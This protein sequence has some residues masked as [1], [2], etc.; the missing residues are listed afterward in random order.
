MLRREALS[1]VYEMSSK[2]RK[3]NCSKRAITLQILQAKKHLKCIGSIYRQHPRSRIWNVYWGYNVVTR[4][5]N[6]SH[7]PGDDR[8]SYWKLLRE[9]LINFEFLRSDVTSSQRT[10]NTFIE[11]SRICCHFQF[12]HIDH[13]A[14]ALNTINLMPYIISTHYIQHASSHKG[15]AGIEWGITPLYTLDNYRFM[16]WRLFVL[17]RWRALWHKF[18]WTRRSYLCSTSWLVNIYWHCK[19]K[20][21]FRSRHCCAGTSWSWRDERRRIDSIGNRIWINANVGTWRMLHS[22]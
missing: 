5:F 10:Y 17:C 8:I 13:E 22:S 3:I 2:R 15:K 7:L 21:S 18:K 9:G 14:V 19:F 6:D 20:D 4:C 11:P 12:G 16:E 1:R